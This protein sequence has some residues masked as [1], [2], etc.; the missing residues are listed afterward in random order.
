MKLIWLL[1]VVLLGVLAWQHFTSPPDPIQV[2]QAAQQYSNRVLDYY[3]EAAR[4][5][6]TD[7]MKAVTREDA[8]DD[9]DRLMQE[10][11]KA[12]MD[13][14]C[15]YAQPHKMTMGGGGAVKVIFMGDPT[16]ILLKADVFVEKDEDTGK[17]WISRTTVD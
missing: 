17:W 7:D 14:G 15:E 9:V 13:L 5:D 3:L 12:E 4:D 16:G 2:R 11:H 8:H 1:V 6:R 10:L